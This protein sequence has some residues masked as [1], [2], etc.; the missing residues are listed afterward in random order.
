MLRT[1]SLAALALGAGDPALPVSAA[2]GSSPAPV[3][4]QESAQELVRRGRDLLAAGRVN[5]AQA[6]FEQA[7]ELEASAAVRFW[8]VRGWVAQGRFEDALVAADE[9]RE[10][11]LP[12]HD[13]DYLLGL[14]FLGRAKAD[15]ASSGGGPYTQDQLGDAYRLL[16]QAT[17]A[18]PLR[19][20]DA[21]LPQAEAGWY[22]LQLEGARAAADRAVELRPQ[23]AAAHALRGKI[24]FSQYSAL[25]SGGDSPVSVE[26]WDVAQR[27][28]RRAIELYGQPAD[29]EGRAALAEAHL[30]CG[31]LHAW[32]QELPAASAAYAEAMGWD[33]SRIDFAQIRAGLGEAFAGCVTEGAQRFRDRFGDQEPVFATLSWWDG[34][35]RFERGDWAASESA[36][37]TAVALWPAYSN[38]WFYV[39]RLCHSQ[40]EYGE[41]VEALRTFARVDLQGLLSTLGA[42]PASQV[43][44]IDFLVGW[45]ADPE[46]HGGSARN[47]DAA[48]LCDVLARLQPEVSRHWNNLGLFVR[49]QGD[50]LRWSARRQG[51]AVDDAELQALWDRATDAYA[52]ALELEPANPNYVNDYAVMLHYYLLRDF[53]QAQEL[54]LRAQR[55]AEERLAQPGLSAAER[56]VVAIALR[57]SKDNQRRLAA[58][59]EKRAA[60]EDVDPNRIR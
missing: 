5:D 15:I 24:A 31:H 57:D 6:L 18:D 50:Q 7:A 28:F 37:R 16:A 13:A 51:A 27:S 43:R 21:W 55:L 4:C 54:Y 19:F 59:L 39:F 3:S 10:A 23:D 53:D 49:D 33:P 26:H 60:G 40:G 56:E 34:Y 11:G 29:A 36:F 20:A 38:S 52:R 45:C 14:A 47:E 46:Q 35:A 8:L 30:Q 32:K 12:G 48:A 22:A 9:L 42:D 58:F 1:L 25:G 2:L 41:A 17:A 44:V